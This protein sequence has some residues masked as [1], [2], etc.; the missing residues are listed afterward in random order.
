M[1]A[2]YGANMGGPDRNNRGCAM[3]KISRTTNKWW[4]AVFWHLI[5]AV[6]HNA[7]VLKY[8]DG[9]GNDR[10]KQQLR[11]RTDLA[12]QLTG[13]YSCRRTAG[14]GRPVSPGTLRRYDGMHHWHQ[15]SP[16]ADKNTPC[17][18]RRA[19]PKR[20]RF[21]CSKC[22]VHLSL[23]HFRAYHTKSNH[24]ETGT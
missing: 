2:D 22:K 9:A 11:F 4:W 13:D 20:T 24:K 6:I 17:K 14:P 1:A 18:C 21:E 19:C 7:W 16:T 3:Y 10:N 5:D 23:D 12:V 8:P 15:R